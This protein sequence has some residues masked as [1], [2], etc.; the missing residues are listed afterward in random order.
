MSEY[1]KALK[2]VYNGPLTNHT[3]DEE[4]EDVLSSEDP[5]QHPNRELNELIWSDS[6]LLK[7]IRYLTDNFAG[8]KSTAKGGGIKVPTIKQRKGFYESYKECTFKPQVNKKS[9]AL[10]K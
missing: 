8:M 3:I 6:D 5:S 2:K 7:A 4:S 9:E 10:E 1:V